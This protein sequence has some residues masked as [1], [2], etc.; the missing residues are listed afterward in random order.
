MYKLIVVG[1]ACNNVHS[2]K[3]EALLQSVHKLFEDALE[4]VG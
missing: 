2:D 3:V 4:D 1:V